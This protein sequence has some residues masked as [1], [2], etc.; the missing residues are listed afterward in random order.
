MQH[1]EAKNPVLDPANGVESVE[2]FRVGAHAPAHV[3]VNRACAREKTHEL[4]DTKQ[5]PIVIRL[6]H[7]PIRPRPKG[8]DRA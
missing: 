4:T 3:K 7:R 8:A 2:F 6:A 1:L 5:N